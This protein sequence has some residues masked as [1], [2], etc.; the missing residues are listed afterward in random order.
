[1][2]SRHRG[3]VAKTTVVSEQ[4][5]FLDLRHASHRFAAYGFFETV[6]EAL[7]EAFF[8]EDLPGVSGSW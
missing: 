2:L 1:M 3:A 5:F 8:S 6:F 7:L 4:I